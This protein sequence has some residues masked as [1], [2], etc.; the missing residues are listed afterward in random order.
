MKLLV[1]ILLLLPI[2]I[3]WYHRIQYAFFYARNWVQNTIIDY[4]EVKP[5][6]PFKP[7]HYIKS[8]YVEDYA[9]IPGTNGCLAVAPTTH[10]NQY[11]IVLDT[12]FVIVNSPNCIVE[13]HPIEEAIRNKTAERYH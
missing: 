6:E 12:G 13:Y 4:E 7:T 3:W 10:P 8:L 1:L 11:R 9:Y 2:G 5:E